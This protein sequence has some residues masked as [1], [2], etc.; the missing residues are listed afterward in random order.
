[1]DVDLEAELESL[2]FE[3]EGGSD[4]EAV[5]GQLPNTGG[6]Q[7]PQ[8]QDT[9]TTQP[10]PSASGAGVR[11]C[12]VCKEHPQKRK[13]RYCVACE[14]DDVAAWVAQHLQ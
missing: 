9:E 11:I 3:N 2:A 10:Q 7:T 5:V 13:S 12:L 14:K 8:P 6:A 4:G 1:M